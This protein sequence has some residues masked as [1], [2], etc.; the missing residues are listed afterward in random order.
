MACAVSWP[1]IKAGLIVGRPMAERGP[2]RQMHSQGLG[3]VNLRGGNVAGKHG[4][5]RCLDKRCDMAR[6]ERAASL[7]G[8]A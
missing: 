6:L 8:H 2:S 1:G 5:S 7:A 4:G 3:S